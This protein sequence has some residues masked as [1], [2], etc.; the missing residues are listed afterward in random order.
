MSIKRCSRQAVMGLVLVIA[1]L[2]A[3]VAQA[4]EWLPEGKLFAPL[5]AANVES[6]TSVSM[7]EFD[8]QDSD[9]VT[10]G[11]TAL[12]FSFPFYRGELPQGEWQLDLF[13][14]V[15]SQFN[16][17]VSNQALINIDYFIGFPLTWREGEWS[18]RARLFHQS[19]HLG[20]EFIL[21]GD[22]PER[23]NLSYEALDLLL[24]REF[25]SGWRLYG[26]GGWVL[27]KQWDAL[28]DVGA[29]VG[30]EYVHPNV[31]FLGGRWVA[32]LDFKWTEAFNDDPQTHLLAGLRWG[33][34]RPGQNSFT[35]AGQVFY[36][37][38][39]FGQFFETSS[40][41]YGVTLIM[42]QD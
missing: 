9:K 1:A 35:L 4:G 7:I 28:G 32:G 30:A 10:I 5:M 36:G 37:A 2:P 41:F 34:N 21:S 39:P 20:D 29:Q 22:A 3:A 19:S 40:F 13:A 12:G 16:L 6:N 11:S 26:G 31:G 24:A 17:D 33:G 42:V 8:S 25:L 15:Q 23:Q 38:V 14:A 18:A 27:R